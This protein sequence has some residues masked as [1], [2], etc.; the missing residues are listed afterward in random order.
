MSSGYQLPPKLLEQVRN[1]FGK[2][3]AAWPEE[4]RDIVNPSIEARDI[5]PPLSGTIKQFINT[6]YHYH[7]A[8]PDRGGTN[9]EHSRV[10]SLLASGW[11]FATT[12]DVSMAAE[13]TVRGRSKEKKS[14]DGKGWTDEI[15]SGD[16]R[17]MKCPM[18]M[19][20]ASRKAQNIAALQLAYGR[21]YDASGR[22]MTAANLIP[23][24]PSGELDGS[25]IDE[26][27]NSSIVSN[28]AEDLAE[29]LK[30]GSPKG[31]SAVS[32]IGSRGE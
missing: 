17:L 31:N 12:D 7:W 3:P 19:W 30:G 11:T 28:P 25:Q 20:R 29:V 13:D 14:K 8:G 32:K 9:E 16:R 21:P 24:F 15:R 18:A 27:R 22:P 2:N 10:E 26:T 6:D 1:D 23:G 5:A 4:L